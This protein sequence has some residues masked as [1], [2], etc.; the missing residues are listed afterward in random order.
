[1]LVLPVLPSNTSKLPQTV[2]ELLRTSSGAQ[3]GVL[4]RFVHHRNS[5]PLPDHYKWV[6][7]LILKGFYLGS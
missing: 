3:R 6:Q 2:R 4:D 7:L 5:T 1:M